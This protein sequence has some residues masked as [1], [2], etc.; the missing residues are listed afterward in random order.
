MRILCVLKF[1]SISSSTHTVICFKTAA[2]YEVM[3]YNGAVACGELALLLRVLGWYKA[4]CSVNN[5]RPL[6]FKHECPGLSCH[7]HKNLG[8]WFP[9]C[10]LVLPLN[11]LLLNL[12]Y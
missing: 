6:A 3:E 1:G 4:P 12:Q 9:F 7:F 10:A 2:G 5:S 8:F 11:C